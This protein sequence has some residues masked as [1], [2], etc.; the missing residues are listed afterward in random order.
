MWVW[1]MRG[2][3]NPWMAQQEKR[4]V[5]QAGSIGGYM[6]FVLPAEALLGLLMAHSMY[7]VA[8]AH[9]ELLQSDR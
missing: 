3:C 6:R 9:G 2:T 5:A 1:A 4:W 7:T 8:L